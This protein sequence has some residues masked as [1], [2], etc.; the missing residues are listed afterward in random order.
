MREN[1]FQTDFLL[2]VPTLTMF[3][4]FKIL[5]VVDLRQL[6]SQKEVRNFVDAQKDW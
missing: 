5:S 1:S 3:S 2:S 4:K 6:R